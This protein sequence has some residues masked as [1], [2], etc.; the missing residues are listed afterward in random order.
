[1][2]ADIFY[3]V[4]YLISESLRNMLPGQLM[5]GLIRPWRGVYKNFDNI[6]VFIYSGHP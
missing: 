1:M 5:L 2:S 6:S 4:I 3:L